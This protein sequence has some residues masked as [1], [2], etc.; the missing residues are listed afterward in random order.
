MTSIDLSFIKPWI[1]VITKAA[2]NSSFRP[3]LTVFTLLAY[4][5]QL[6]AVPVFHA[7]SLDQTL[8]DQAMV[9]VGVHIAGRSFEKVKGVA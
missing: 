7:P 1:P 2:I 5:Y 3:A 4:S 6:V 8:L 9:L